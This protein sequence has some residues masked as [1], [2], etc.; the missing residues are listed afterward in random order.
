MKC[1]Q[2]NCTSEAEKRGFCGQHYRAALKNGTLP[3]VRFKGMSLEERIKRFSVKNEETGCLE[4]TGPKT[5]S[6]YGVYCPTEFGP[7]L[8]AHRIAWELVFGKIQDGLIVC[9]T[10]D[11]RAC[12]NPNHMFLGTNKTNAEDRDTKG[13][14]VKGQ[15]HGMAKLKEEQVKRILSDERKIYEIAQEFGVSRITIGDIK[16]R[17]R[18]KYLHASAND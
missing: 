9:H 8:R 3:R 2:E 1:K 7:K 15:L 13:R 12:V 16:R 11:N 4:W 17:K 5:D 14:Q 18:W 6:G 10:C